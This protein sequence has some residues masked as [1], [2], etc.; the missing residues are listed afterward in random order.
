MIKYING[1]ILFFLVYLFFSCDEWDSR[2]NLINKTKYK[3]SH[4]ET[5]NLNDSAQNY[6]EFYK[7]NFINNNSDTFKVRHF[8]KYAWLQ[9]IN[10]Q[11]FV[12]TIIYFL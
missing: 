5:C 1:I 3:L 4:Y 7:I 8:G 10:I 11:C 6:F 2:L 9:E 12:W